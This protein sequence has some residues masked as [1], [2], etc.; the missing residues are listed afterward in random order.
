MSTH[1]AV[2]TAYLN[3]IRTVFCGAAPLGS[4]DEAKF[5][6]KAGRKNINL[7]QGMY[8]N[9]LVIVLNSFGKEKT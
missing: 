7:F 2:K 4:L 5:L 9:E 3:S 1:P 8:L 6:E